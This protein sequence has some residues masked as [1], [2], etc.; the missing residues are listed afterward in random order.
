MRVKLYGVKSCKLFQ[1]HRALSVPFAD[2]HLYVITVMHAMQE[3]RH[4][5][6]TQVSSVPTYKK[7]L[8]VLEE[9]LDALHQGKTF[10]RLRLPSTSKY[11]HWCK[12]SLNI[13]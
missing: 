5:L 1:E 3:L 12:K 7:R 8:M 13:V 4:R 11:F 10:H 6:T 9:A 2:V